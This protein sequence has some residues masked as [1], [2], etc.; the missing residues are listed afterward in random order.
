MTADRSSNGMTH[1]S[2]SMH[3]LAVNETIVKPKLLANGIRNAI[4]CSK[5]VQSRIWRRRWNDAWM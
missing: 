4:Y 2:D 5:L 3:A 1:L